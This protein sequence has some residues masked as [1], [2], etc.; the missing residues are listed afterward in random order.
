MNCFV[1]GTLIKAADGHK[2]VEEIAVGDKVWAYDDK[3]GKQGLKAV[4][5]LFRNTTKELGHI[6]I[7]G[8][9]IT[10]TNEHPFYVKNKG[11]V[12][13][14]ELTENMVL[15]LQNGNFASIKSIEFETCHEPVAIYNFEVE[16]YHTYYVTKNNILV[17]NTCDTKNEIH[18]IVERAQGKASRRGFSK[19]LIERIDN[20]ISL[21]K[22]V[23]KEISR[24]YSSLYKDTGMTFRNFLTNNVKLFSEQHAIGMKIVHMAKTGLPIII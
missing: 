8:E 21:T 22:E 9:R 7:D 17:H 18:H 6:D 11:W 4:K 15:C 14:C 23:H 3:T 1:A 2:K 24:F 12:K 19:L 10:T 16:D 13:A 5:Q 20:K